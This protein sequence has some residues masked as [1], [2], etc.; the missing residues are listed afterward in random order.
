MTVALVLNGDLNNHADFNCI[1]LYES[2]YCTDGAYNILKKKKIAVHA[3]I[4][5][6]DSIKQTTHQSDRFVHR[7][8][9][10]FTD[11]DK[12][13]AYLDELQVEKID[14]FGAS[15]NEQD[16]FLGNLYVA[17]K[18]KQ[19][20]SLMFYD[21]YQRYFLAKSTEVIDNILG[22]TVSLMP[23]YQADKI[24][25]S[26]LQYPLDQASLGFD[27]SIGI[28]NKAVSQRVQ[29]KHS[30]GDLIIFVER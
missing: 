4:G 28:R 5:D 3:V 13:L 22:K 26:G 20:F 9:Q 14:V 2:I 21:Q 16:H 24:T 27:S 17:R 23:F 30:S 1:R 6:F 29:I 19:R 7:P 18:W 25:T 8:D 11:F 15:G 10:N 12:A